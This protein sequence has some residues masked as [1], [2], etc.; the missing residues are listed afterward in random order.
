[1]WAG[2]KK[3]E[4][5]QG[6]QMSKFHF[7]FCVKPDDSH[8]YYQHVDFEAVAEGIQISCDEPNSECVHLLAPDKYKRFVEALGQESMTD[9]IEAARAAVKENKRPLVF[10]AVHEFAE[11][12]FTWYGEDSSFY[13]TEDRGVQRESI[14]KVHVAPP[15][16]YENLTDEEKTKWAQKFAQEFFPNIQGVDKDIRKIAD[17]GF[18]VDIPWDPFDD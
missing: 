18:I 6:R 17:D 11:V 15:L 14:Q 13:G 2:P 7:S 3:H 4:T 8:F 16:D 1:M 5:C 9:P 12:K 10:E